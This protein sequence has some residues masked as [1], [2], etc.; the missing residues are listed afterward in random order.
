M[1]RE[2]QAEPFDRRAPTTP[3]LEFWALHVLQELPQDCHKIVCL[4]DKEAGVCGPCLFNS[5]EQARRMAHDYNEANMEP[6]PLTIPAIYK[7]LGDAAKDGHNVCFINP[8]RGGRKNFWQIAHIFARLP[9]DAACPCGSGMPL[10]RC[11]DAPRPLTQQAHR[12]PVLLASDSLPKEAK[13][14][15]EPSVEDYSRV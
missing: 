10:E 9:R 2:I 3:P 4:M 14:R 7:I 15:S 1:D 6:V 8:M 13:E 5:A 11:C 12:W